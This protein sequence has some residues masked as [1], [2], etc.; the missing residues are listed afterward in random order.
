[1]TMRNQ[2]HWRGRGVVER[3]IRMSPW[4]VCV[5]IVAGLVILALVLGVICMSTAQKVDGDGE[6]VDDKKWREI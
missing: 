3:K 6:P 4:Y 5:G 1:M 2:E